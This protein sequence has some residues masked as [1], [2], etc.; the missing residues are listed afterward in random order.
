[1]LRNIQ[2]ELADFEYI[3]KA[4]RDRFEKIAENGKANECRSVFTSPEKRVFLSDTEEER[5]TLTVGDFVEVEGDTSPAMN[6]ERGCGFITKILVEDA[7]GTLSATVKYLLDGKSRSS[8][9]LSDI[10]V[11]DYQAYFSVMNRVN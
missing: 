3:K 9:P 2:T 4:N 7:C 10:T 8:I 11:K 1:M 6:R 5:S